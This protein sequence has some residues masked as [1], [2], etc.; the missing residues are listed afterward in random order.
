LQ[1]KR[2]IKGFTEAVQMMV[3]GETRRMW[4][5]EELAYGATPRET[6][7]KGMLIFEVELLKI[8]SN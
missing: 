5:P 8:F 7:P 4:I 3:E 6:A 1:L 2:T